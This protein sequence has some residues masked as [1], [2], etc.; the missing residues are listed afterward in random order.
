[1]HDGGL[2]IG[3][4]VIVFSFGV[5]VGDS[6]ALRSG[7][8][9]C[10]VENRVSKRGE[11]VEERGEKTIF[12]EGVISMIWRVAR[13]R[14]RRGHT[15]LDKF[16]RPI[17]DGGGCG[18][19]KLDDERLFV[20]LDFE[21]TGWGDDAMISAHTRTEATGTQLQHLTTYLTHSP[22]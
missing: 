7:Q 2:E 16:Q 13:W 4:D 19:V 3:I 10:G 8:G 5:G 9:R 22:E 17:F 15:M 21:R 1:M 14:N 18:E 6:R 20:S 12:F 11:R